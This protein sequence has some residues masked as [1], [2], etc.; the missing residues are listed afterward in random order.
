MNAAGSEAALRQTCAADPESLPA[1]AVKLADEEPP[2]AAVSAREEGAAA[3]AQL[4][5]KADPAA[6]VESG[7]EAS[8]AAS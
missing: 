1:V 8:S 4:A 5:G 2:D 6:A 7:C 3:A